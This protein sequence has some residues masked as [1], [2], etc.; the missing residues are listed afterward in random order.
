MAKPRCTLRVFPTPRARARTATLRCSSPESTHLGRLVQSGVDARFQMVARFSRGLEVDTPWLRSRRLAKREATACRFPEQRLSS[1]SP[2]YDPVTLGVR[3]QSHRHQQSLGRSAA[4]LRRTC[5]SLGRVRAP[6]LPIYRGPGRAGPSMAGEAL[7]K[8]TESMPPE[9]AHAR[10]G[11]D[12]APAILWKRWRPVPQA[13]SSAN[14]ILDPER[15]HHPPPSA[16]PDSPCCLTAGSLRC[17][18]HF[19]RTRPAVG[20]G[21]RRA[22]PGPP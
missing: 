13:T 18:M 3:I 12:S 2:P 7:G 10:V 21:V 17:N 11:D 15:F 6:D 16:A 22:R 5:S 19:S 14:S 8:M 20:A 4:R 1:R 9:M